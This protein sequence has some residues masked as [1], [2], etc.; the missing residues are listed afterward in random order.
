MIGRVLDDPARGHDRLPHVDGGN[1]R[2]HG[3][4]SYVGATYE[5]AASAIS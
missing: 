1:R 4:V 5:I 2:S 3:V